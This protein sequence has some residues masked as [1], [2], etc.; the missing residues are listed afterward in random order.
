M[1]LMTEKIAGLWPEISLLLGACSCIAAGLAGTV[2]VRRLAA[3]IAAVALAVAGVATLAGASP[4]TSIHIGAHGSSANG[5]AAPLACYVKIAV[6]GV[7]LLLLLVAAAVPNRIRSDQQVDNAPGSAFDAGLV[8]RGEFFAFFLLS[9]TG[10]M[11]VSGATDLV[12]LFLALELTS[13]PTYVMVATARDRVEANEAAVKY[14]FLGALAAAVFLYGFTLLYGA[15]G[16]TDLNV[17]H[18]VAKHQL[19]HGGLSPLLLTG[20]LLSIV[21][22]AFKIAAVPMHF[23]AADVY[24]GASTAVT[25]FLA[26]VPKTA[27]FV[28]LILILGITGD[29]TPQPVIWLLW[30]MEA[31]TMT[32]G[33]VMGLLQTNVKRVLA[34]SSI[35]HSGYMLLGLVALGGHRAGEAA[36]L[37]YV[38]GY[39]LAT[40][41]A[42]AVLGCLETN[43]DESQDYA[44]I[45]GLAKRNPGLAATLLLAV[46]S[47]IGMPP[48]VGFLGKVYLFTSA[49]DH[50]YVCLVV[51]AAINS[52][53]GAVYYLRIASA[54]YFG[55]P[56]EAT[57]VIDWPSRRVG[58]TAAAVIALAL[59]IVGGPLVEAASLAV[60]API[61]HPTHSTGIVLPPADDE[62][63]EMP[64]TATPQPAAPTTAPADDA[65]AA[66][67][68]AP[69]PAPETAPSE[70]AGKSSDM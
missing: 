41:A 3:P 39:G 10:V 16:S 54:C 28:A 8:M 53:I 12:W 61:G 46:L 38:V 60:D 56:D 18:N 42:F 47:L 37:F 22:I 25:A 59:G 44:H 69:Q 34:Y 13:L 35:A 6:V 2:S 7:G 24:Q 63:G 30:A 23:Y 5:I 26:F 70:P 65:P 32:I 45:A 51:I 68:T 11:L 31:L 33:N 17:I 19:A 67:E 9:L 64:D 58:G 55:K 43:G 50:G 36:V 52:A 29:H 20:M 57:R 21:G 4:P 62:R 40:I 48:L 15:T 1:N 66:T 49:I 14:F 27:G